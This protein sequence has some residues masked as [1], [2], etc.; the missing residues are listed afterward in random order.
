MDSILRLLYLI[1]IIVCSQAFVDSGLDSVVGTAGT[2]V[3]LYR[4]VCL[5][6]NQTIG[7]ARPTD[8]TLSGAHLLQMI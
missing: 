4:F 7:T 8:S 1:F 3:G 2:L 5:I 6:L